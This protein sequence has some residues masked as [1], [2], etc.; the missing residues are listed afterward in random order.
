MQ[1]A[2]MSHQPRSIWLVP[3]SVELRRQ[4][5]ACVW[6]AMQAV[7]CRDWCTLLGCRYVGRGLPLCSHVKAAA[8]GGV[9]HSM[10]KCPAHLWTKIMQRSRCHQGWSS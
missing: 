7:L 4:L 2:C 10:R 3:T 8:D 9:L 6:V 1:L 5:H